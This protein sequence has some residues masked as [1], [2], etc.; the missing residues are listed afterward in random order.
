MSGLYRACWQVGDGKP[1]DY[2][3]TLGDALEAAFAAGHRELG[4]L[5]A[6]LNAAGALAPDGTPWTEARFQAEM[7][8]LGA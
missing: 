3:R 8:R 1:T 7:R 5:V 2:E 4:A 6:A